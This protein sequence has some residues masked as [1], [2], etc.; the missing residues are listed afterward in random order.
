MKKIKNFSETQE[1]Q[2][3]QETPVEEGGVTLK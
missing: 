2:E 1:T 3:R